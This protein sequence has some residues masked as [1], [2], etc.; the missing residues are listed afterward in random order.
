MRHYADL[1]RA[2][3]SAL[4]MLV[5]IAGTALAGPYEDSIAALEH[6][7]YPTALRLLRPLADQGN[8]SAQSVLGLMYAIGQGVRQNYAE[9]AKW[10]RK[11][12]DQGDATAQASLG[13]MYEGGVGVPKDYI[14][15]HKW[16][17]LSLAR[18]PPG[19]MHDLGVKLRDSVAAKMTPVQIAEAQKLAREWKPKS[20]Q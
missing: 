16:F 10:L 17:N 9:A 15:A 5:V 13:N 6:G 2:T 11:A 14:Q 8:A 1:L 12:A 18:A 4:L 3:L 20:S 19:E 7:D